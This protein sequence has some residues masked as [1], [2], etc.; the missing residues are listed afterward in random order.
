MKKKVILSVL[1]VVVF[2]FIGILIGI[3]KVNSEN[4]KSKTNKYKKEISDVLNLEGNKSVIK[5]IKD[6]I[7]YDKIEDYVVLLGEEKYDDISNSSKYLNLNKTL[8]MYNNI[9]V[10]YINGST[11]EKIRYNTNKSY[12]TDVD[13]NLTEFENN[14]YI[15][16]ADTIN[17]NV[18]VLS[19]LEN[20]VKDYISESFTNFVGYTID[21]S[22]DDNEKKLKI[23]LD[24]YGRNYLQS[25][26]DEYYI[27]LSETNV[28]STTYRITY[29]AN[30]FCKFELNIDENNNLCIIATQ[31]VLYSN[32]KNLDK[33]FGKI[34]TK[35]CLDMDE[36][37]FKFSDVYVES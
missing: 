1:V 34:N 21:A 36:N 31:Y 16:L 28:N 13:I 3:C 8:E 18:A 35:F 11:K 9:S 23:K 37:K 33:N 25:K 17:G 27:D 14:K 19:L 24:N 5:I 22:I 26:T 32:D 10:E 15:L 30:K 12:G 7:D 2:T 4:D 29:M 20:T 6:D